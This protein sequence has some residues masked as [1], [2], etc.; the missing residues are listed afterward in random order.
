MNISAAAVHASLIKIAAAA[1][2]ELVHT[3]DA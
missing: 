2:A 3:P 1:V